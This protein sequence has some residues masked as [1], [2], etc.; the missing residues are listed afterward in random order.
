MP[1]MVPR[2]VKPRWQIAVLEQ[3]YFY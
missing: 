3:L 2:Q 1:S